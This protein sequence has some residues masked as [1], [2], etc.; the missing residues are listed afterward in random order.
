M[1][2]LQIT[3]DIPIKKILKNNFNLVGLPPHIN[4]FIHGGRKRAPA[5]NTKQQGT[6][7][8]NVKQ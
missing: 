8:G 1:L 7:V 5:F 6:S 3:H 4:V 2:F